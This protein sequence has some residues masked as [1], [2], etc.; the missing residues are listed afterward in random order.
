M[1]SSAKI[2]AIRAMVGASTKLF[3]KT[4]V[5]HQTLNPVPPT[6]SRSTTRPRPTRLIP[7][8][9]TQDRYLSRISSACSS[10]CLRRDVNCPDSE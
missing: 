5:I 1:A 3:S 10:T 6:F 7:R 9:S 2:L 8:S 4:L